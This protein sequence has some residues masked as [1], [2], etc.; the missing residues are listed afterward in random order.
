MLSLAHLGVQMELF[1]ELNGSS[2]SV[3]ERMEL[4]PL[5]LAEWLW[6]W[7][8]L[9]EIEEHNGR[10][11]ARGSSFPEMAI[12]ISPFSAKREVDGRIA[13]SPGRI[14]FSPGRIILSRAFS[15]PNLRL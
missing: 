2:S 8:R 6:L 7:L 10:S 4:R 5:W 13:F 9:L 15:K 14:G 1:L 3:E 12:M 11:S